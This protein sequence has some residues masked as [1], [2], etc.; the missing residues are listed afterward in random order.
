[1]SK[2]RERC[3]RAVLFSTLTSLYIIPLY[4]YGWSMQSMLAKFARIVLPVTSVLS[5]TYAILC[6]CFR[7]FVNT[8]TNAN[9]QI[10]SS[11]TIRGCSICMRFKPSR[12]HHCKRCKACIKKMDHHCHW[13]GRCINY[14]NLGHFARFMLF[15]FISSSIII[16]LNV[17]YIASLV[18]FSKQLVPIAKAT[19]ALASTLVAILVASVTGVHT[20]SQFRMIANNIT[21][22][23]LLQK[24]NYG[25]RK[26]RYDSIYNVGLLENLTDVFG[27]PAYL[28]LGMPNGDGINFKR[29][30]VP[31]PD[32]VE[33]E[34]SDLFESV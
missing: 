1:M 15:T 34:D 13:L 16:L 30:I 6:L 32:F 4:C 27:S 18:F 25:V 17:Y 5:L 24:E 29:R 21:Y 7:G 26:D 11:S 12:A 22:V 3:E 20:F 10:L 9:D 8:N 2:A 14:D 19:V 31:E 23:E 28:F 33:S